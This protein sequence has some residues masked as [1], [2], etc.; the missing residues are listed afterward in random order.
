LFV[1]SFETLYVTRVLLLKTATTKMKY[2]ARMSAD[3]HHLSFCFFAQ[4]LNSFRRVFPFDLIW[5]ELRLTQT[6]RQEERRRRGRISENVSVF[7]TAAEL[8]KE[9]GKKNLCLCIYLLVRSFTFFL[10]FSQ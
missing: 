9:G 2:S 5:A 10:L 4:F 1:L 3:I 7:R 8:A 6:G